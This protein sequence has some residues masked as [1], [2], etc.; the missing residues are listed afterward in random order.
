MAGQNTAQLVDQQVQRWEASRGGKPGPAAPCIAIARMPSAGGTEVGRRVAARLDYGLFGREIV[1]QIAREE[2]I[3]L[4]LVTGLDEHS[5]TSIQR[6]VVDGFSHRAFTESDYLRDVVQIVTT[7]G[8]R[9]HSVIVGRGASYILPADRALRVL[10]AA[11]G[12]ARADWYAARYNLDGREAAHRVAR[13]DE[14]RERFIRQDFN[15][16]YLDPSLYDL[17]VNTEVLGLDLAA[18]LVL[19]AYRRRFPS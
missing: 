11:S 19:D 1:E 10:V 3:R 9:G 12:H 16:S 14:Q 2:G 5:A 17:V 4:S 6:L 7:L 18:E 15:L 8:Q 13:Q